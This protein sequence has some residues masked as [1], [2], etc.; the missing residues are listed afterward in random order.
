MPILQMTEEI[1]GKKE[2]PRASWKMTTGGK[3]DAKSNISDYHLGLQIRSLVLVQF[4]FLPFRSFALCQAVALYPFGFRANGRS[5]FPGKPRFTQ[6]IWGGVQH[7]IH[8]A[9]RLST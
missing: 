7:M 1:K 8:P 3:R 9:N 6:R 2:I 5:A 4:L